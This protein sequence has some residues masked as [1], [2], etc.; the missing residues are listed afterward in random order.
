MSNILPL[1]SVI[2]V[3]YNNK[4]FLQRT[5]ES[6]KE[7]TYS[8]IEYIVVDG[9]STDG[10]LDVIQA[11]QEIISQWISEPDQ[12]IYDAMNKGISLAKGE[13]INFMNAG[14]IFF[15][16]TTVEE[17]VSYMGHDDVDAVYGNGILKNYQKKRERF[18]DT[19]HHQMKIN[20]QSLFYRK[21]LHQKYGLYLVAPGLTI[22][23]YLF[24]NLIKQIK[25]K[26]TKNPISINDDG[27][28]SNTSKAFYL[29]MAVDILFGNR[30][31]QKAAIYIL[32]FPILYPSYRTLKDMLIKLFK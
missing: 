6:V 18:L 4:A 13:W 12:G 26:K 14:D 30:S 22:A 17:V 11:N 3:V 24:F 27:G 2:T 29:K 25:W 19:D 28:V 7:Q 15:N 16:S 32:L 31:Y 10:T 23:D 8:N 5:I 9:N 1:L 21:V 20:H